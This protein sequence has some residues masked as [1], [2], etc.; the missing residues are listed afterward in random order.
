MVFSVNRIIWKIA[1]VDEYSPHL[2]RSDGT[3]SVGCTDFGGRTVFIADNLSENFQRKVLLHEICHCICFSY[4]L[5]FDLQTEETICDF[6][7]TYGTEAIA[8]LENL[9]IAMKKAA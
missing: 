4:G 9:T 3:I 1:Y 7:A 8:L 2:M 6:V 5:Y